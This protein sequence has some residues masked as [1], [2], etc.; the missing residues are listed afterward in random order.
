[1][2]SES[3]AVLFYI[4]LSRRRGLV[5]AG[6]ALLLLA[7]SLVSLST[8]S[9]SISLI[10]IIHALTGSGSDSM[11]HH[12]VWGIRLPRL[13]AAVLAGASLGLAGCVLQAVLKNPLASPTTLGVSQGAAFGAAC[14]IIL[15]DSGL[16]FS[17]GNEAVM[18]TSRWTTALCAF[19]GALIP[20]MLT[21]AISTMRQSSGES[22]VLAGVA[23]GAFLSACTMLLQYFASDMQVAATLFWTFGDLGKGGWPENRILAALFIPVLAYFTAK[24]WSFN[25]LLAG[26]DVAS[27]LGVST[28]RL[29]ITGLLLTSLLVSAATAFLGIIA[30]IGLMAPH[31]IRPLAG[32]D[33]RFLIPASSL[34][35][36]IIL[37]LADCLSR[38][39]LAPVIIPVGIIT[40]FAGA[41][42]FLWLLLRRKTV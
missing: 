5:L 32:T 21:G 25:A 36:A 4:S 8:G 9:Y 33:H 42:V 20:A 11:V 2:Q 26:E 24:G 19:A 41:P 14:A 39:V 15:L 31:I 35:G 17:T 28:G 10:Q 23:A 40:S 38:A 1:M 27:S 12:L 6:L 29:R 30:F 13:V 16:T 18:I 7:F 34:C 3:G 22:L 37:L